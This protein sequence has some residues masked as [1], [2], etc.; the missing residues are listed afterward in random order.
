MG[1][2]G[3]ER[4]WRQLG[5]P[6]GCG[7]WCGLVGSGRGWGQGR[8]ET[9]G[10]KVVEL[11]IAEVV[12]QAPPV[13]DHLVDRRLVAPG[14]DPLLGQVPEPARAAGSLVARVDL[15][16]SRLPRA[17]RV[18]D[19]G[20]RSVRP[21]PVPLHAVDVPGQLP[22]PADD[23]E[24]LLLD[25]PVT[26]GVTLR[27]LADLLLRSSWITVVPASV[28]LRCL[29]VPPSSVV[30]CLVVGL[31]LRCLAVV[32]GV[33]VRALTDL[34]LRRLSRLVPAGVLFVLAI[35]VVRR[36]VV[37]VTGLGADVDLFRG[38]FS[39]AV[40][41]AGVVFGC[42]VG[43]AWLLTS[44]FLVRFVLRYLVVPVGGLRFRGSVR[45]AVG[46][47]TLL[48]GVTPG[49]SV[50]VAARE[51][52][53]G[54]TAGLDV[55]GGVRAVVA[56]RGGVEGPTGPG[57]GGGAR[58]VG[59]GIAGVRL[60]CRRG[61]HDGEMS[62]GAGKPRPEPRHARTVAVGARPVTCWPGHRVM[63]RRSEGRARFVAVD[64]GLLWTAVGS[65]AGVLAAVIAWR[66]Y[67]LEAHHGPGRDGA[68]SSTKGV[69][70]ASVLPPI[71]RLPP[72]VRGR[73]RILGE[74]LA[75]L[76]RPTGELVVLSGMGGVGKSTVAVSLA[77]R[78]ADLRLGIRRRHVDVWWVSVAD[79]SSLTSAMVAV[80]RKLGATATD[81]DA[82]AVGRP[83]AP[84]R[85][86]ELLERA[87]RRWLLLLDNADDPEVLARP[88]SRTSPTGQPPAPSSAT[89]VGDG[90]GWARP[91]RQG[92]V[93]ITSRDANPRTWG[94]HA[95]V[96]DLDP[97]DAA[98]AARVLLDW[99]PEAGTEAEAVALA[100]RLGR[101]P[102]ALGLAGSYL[103]S[104]VAL[105]PTFVEYQRSLDSRYDAA[106]LLT[107]ERVG[108]T[109]QR[110]VVMR[111]WELSLDALDR[112]GVPQARPL[113]RL[114]ACFAASTPIPLDLLDPEYLVPLLAAS[115]DGGPTPAAPATGTAERDLEVGLRHLW[116][117]RLI[118][119]RP[120]ASRNE[121]AVAVHPVIADTNRAHLDGVADAAVDAALV[122]RTAAELVARDLE[123]LDY[124]EPAHWP[125]YRALAPHLHA[126]FETV[127]PHLASDRVGGLL[128]AASRAAAAHDRLG[129]P[130]AGERLLQAALRT[131]CT[132]SGDEPA[133][134]LVRHML[135]WEIAVRGRPDD[136]EAL[137]RDVFVRRERVLGPDHPE[138]L[139]SRNELAW[140]AAIRG[141]WTGAEEMYRDVLARRERV[142]GAEH[143]DTLISRHELAWC[144]ASQGRG[145]EAEA[146]LREVIE[147]RAR[148]FRPDHPRALAS[149]HELAWAIA[150]QG[151][152]GE[153]EAAYR[154]VLAA[155]RA[156]LGIEH[157]ESLT[158]AHELTWVI[159]MQGAHRRREAL[160]GYEHVLAARQ[161]VLG[162]EHP[163]T[164]A[165][166]HALERLRDGET[167][168]AHHMA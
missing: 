84:D 123:R 145:A 165:T 73:G 138:T 62:S 29:V 5:Q 115:R 148:V 130:A 12:D 76:R 107:S 91:S 152:W 13:V 167:T 24:R 155:R 65:L 110:G 78:A 144:M 51:V 117:Y 3:S 80:A 68:R 49:A 149:R 96:L 108:T 119:A 25:L 151:R 54:S 122:R 90:D 166:R 33:A 39:N 100:E 60:R 127:A 105:K 37:L 99:A 8:E 158:T 135:A 58:L 72:E 16:P 59:R 87:P 134:L 48:G 121:Q 7:G 77:G 150:V 56:R 67:R 20:L 124:D 116:Q 139:H 88:A 28:E 42:L 41:L 69:R 31:V 168:F 132:L 44:G 22:E 30:P 106:H 114:L 141:E 79:R 118:D 153:A 23:Q 131:S 113:L 15:A 111:T 98:D 40:A 81:L 136:A 146:L 86:W 89:R 85:L 129:D 4:E 27:A 147:A 112:R 92:V 140:M 83:D 137:Y 101:L 45:M 10:G 2:G 53:G 18:V 97:L 95:R 82:I 126:L 55:G 161:R 142:L 120:R 71:G 94:R 128:E 157:P 26:L 109:G 125:R 133:C 160:T 52:L 164:V 46:R 43:G 34:L 143:R 70:G 36:L 47:L 74:L 103:E 6:V 21:H 17:G 11:G 63:P 66:Q 159:A 163:D 64:A 156:V 32:V 61:P 93:V 35:R 104:E 57:G 38:R 75:L 19:V 154:D 1:C 9:D 14:R 50:V 162:A 102:L